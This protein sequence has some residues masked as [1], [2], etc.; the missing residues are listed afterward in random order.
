MSR[1]A[2]LFN[3][4]IR[5]RSSRLSSGPGSTPPNALAV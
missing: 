4:R 1:Y 3:L 2:S 5:L